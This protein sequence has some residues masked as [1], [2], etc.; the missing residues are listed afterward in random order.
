MVRI[1]GGWDTLE[2]YLDRHDPCRCNLKPGTRNMSY[3]PTYNLNYCVLRISESPKWIVDI[4]DGYLSYEEM[5]QICSRRMDSVLDP[6]INIACVS[7][8]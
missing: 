6:F 1:G 5:L 3:L 2:N 7:V 4:P 8:T